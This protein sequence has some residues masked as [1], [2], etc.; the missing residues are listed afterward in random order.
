MTDSGK[1]KHHSLRIEFGNFALIYTFIKMPRTSLSL[2]F[3]WKYTFI[4]LKFKPSFGLTD[5]GPQG[6]KAVTAW[7][8]VMHDVY[9]L[10]GGGK[11]QSGLSDTYWGRI[12]G[13]ENEIMVVIG[14]ILL[15]CCLLMLKVLRSSRHEA[16]C[17]SSPSLTSKQFDRY[18][19]KHTLTS[20]SLS[21]PYTNH[22]QHTMERPTAI[23]TARLDLLRAQPLSYPQSRRKL[24]KYCS[25][26]FG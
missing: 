14:E 20:R 23:S 2:E 1:Y 6:E 15:P 21:S 12:I 9:F 18:N 17:H 16:F 24:E 19:P 4:K 13:T 10:G 11:F 5:D 3:G 7:E 25:A 22:Y 26:K 8:T